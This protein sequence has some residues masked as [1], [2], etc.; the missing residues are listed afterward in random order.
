MRIARCLLPILLV[1]AGC[2]P[3]S[4]TVTAPDAT[5]GVPASPSSVPAAPSQDP[6]APPTVGPA[7]TPPSPEQAQSLAAGSNT[8]A[9]DLYT[10]LRKQ[11][12][13]LAVSPASITLALAMT[14]GGAKGPTSD[15]MAK[16]LH[17]PNAKDATIDAAGRQLSVWNDPARTVYTLRVAN[18]LFGE[19]SYTF[20][21]AYLKKTGEAFGA[22]LEPVD[23]KGAAE[24]ARERINGWVAKE[25]RDRIK[26]L[27]PPRSVDK[28]TRLVLVNAIYFLG[29]WQSP[30]S[31]ERTRPAPFFTTATTSKDVPTMSQVA[32]FKHAAVDGL[33]VLEM[34]YV[35]GELAMTFLLPNAKDGLDALEQKL[36]DGKLTSW[37]AA[38]KPERVLVSLPVFEID[39]AEPLSLG[40][41]LVAMGMKLAFDPDLADFT[42]IASPP[43]PADRL[44]IG[45][46]FHK[47]FV[48][49]NEKGTEAAAATAVVM[50]RAGS[51][52]PAPPPEFRADHPFLF[53]LRDLRTGMILFMGRVVEPAKV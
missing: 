23:F 44:Y 52:A 11:P 26:N 47:A 53:F 46:V 45:K 41:E 4:P 5:P 16:V 37:I 20:E 35:G 40:K 43:S 48:K 6:A 1:C 49:V 31:K 50:P 51:A 25:T 22:P 15:E 18:R 42:G 36:T 34:P 12:G 33:Q 32:S 7:P 24:P 10:R 38:A 17:L 2:T 14:W 19:K 13:N 29:D 39:P 8:F 9:M 21:P 30:F 3:P 28:E 27:L